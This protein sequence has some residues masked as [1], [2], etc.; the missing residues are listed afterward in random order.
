MKTLNGHQ[1]SCFWRGLVKKIECTV[2]MASMEETSEKIRS[3]NTHSALRKAVH[4]D[5]N[6]HSLE[7]IGF[8]SILL[9]FPSHNS[10]WLS[11]GELLH[12]WRRLIK[13]IECTVIM[14]FM[15]EG[16]KKVPSKNIH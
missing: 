10:V 5:T 6:T 3:K 16:P 2:I 15:D 1:L 9:D 8:G 14:A 11:E 4:N 7:M 12:F 13:K